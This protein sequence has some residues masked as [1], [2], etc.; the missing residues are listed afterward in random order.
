MNPRAARTY[1]IYIYIIYRYIDIYIE[2]ERERYMYR[3]RYINSCRMASSSFLFNFILLCIFSLTLFMLSR[4][5]FPT[6]AP[7]SLR[8]RESGDNGFLFNYNFKLIFVVFLGL[9]NGFVDLCCLPNPIRLLFRASPT[10]SI[11]T[12]FLLAASAFRSL[13]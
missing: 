13:A 7:L 10:P 5:H 9:V 2:R 8:L 12:S 4:E 11:S 6:N 3:K 1:V